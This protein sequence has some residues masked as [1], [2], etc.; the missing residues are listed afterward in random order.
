MSIKSTDR[1]LPPDI[2]QALQQV[3]SIRAKCDEAE[4]LLTTI[5]SMPQLTKLEDSFIAGVVEAKTGE[6]LYTVQELNRWGNLLELWA[7]KQN[8][9]NP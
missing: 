9:A 7:L 3:R 5:G 6:L 8:H 1:Y 2:Q 4:T